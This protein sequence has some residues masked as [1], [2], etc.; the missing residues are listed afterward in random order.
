MHFDFPCV[1]ID[2]RACRLDVKAIMQHRW[3]QEPMR[4]ELQCA[5]DQLEQEQASTEAKVAA[6][7]YR[8]KA[9]D[10]AICN[11]IKLAASDEF[12]QRVGVLIREGR[13]WDM[14]VGE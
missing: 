9:R 8:S 3:Y 2:M 13:D 5:S 7:A 14:S 11:L 4:T 12:R 6:G 10:Q 1:L